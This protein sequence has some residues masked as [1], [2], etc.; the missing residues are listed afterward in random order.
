[1]SLKQRCI[2]FVHSVNMNA[3]LR[4]NSPVDDLVDFVR[5]EIGKAADEVLD[6]TEPLV[7]YFADDKD[8]K[9]FVDAVL[10]ARPGMISRQWPR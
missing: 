2:N 8:R 7:L 1:V 3:M 5:A 9:E 6:G 4:Q 10:Q